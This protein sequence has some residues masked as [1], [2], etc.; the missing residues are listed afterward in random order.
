[1]VFSTARA[2]KKIIWEQSKR[3]ITGTLVALSPIEDKFRQQCKIAVVAARPLTGV[4]ANPPEVDLFF[5]TPEE[6]E[7]DSL[8][9][10]LMVEA[11]TGYFEAYRHTLVGLQRMI[12][13]EYA[14]MPSRTW[15]GLKLTVTARFPMSEH[16]VDLKTTIDK[17]GYTLRIPLSSKDVETPSAAPSENAHLLELLPSSA[18]AALDES[19]RKALERILTKKLA[20]VQGPPGTGKTHVSVTALKFLLSRATEA[21]PP[22]VIAS[23]T[24]HALD[25]MLRHISGFEP[26]FV[27]LGGRSSDQDVIKKRTVYQL[28]RYGQVPNIPGSL[29]GPALSTLRRQEHTMLALLDPIHDQKEPISAELL[30]NLE[31]LTEAQYRS[32]QGRATGWVQALK[33]DHPSGSIAAWLGDELVGVG[34][35]RQQDDLDLEYEDIDPEFEQIKETEAEAVAN[36][37]ENID[38]LSGTWRSISERFQARQR[39]GVTMQAVERA[40]QVDNLWDIPSRMRGAIYT[41]FQQSVKRLIR[42]S[43]R[44]EAQIYMKAVKELQIG[45]WETDSEILRSAKLIGMTT[46]GLS[47][48]RPL[49][50]SVQ[51]RIML[52]EEAAETLE[53]LI[54][55]GCVESLKHL[56]LVG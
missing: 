19:Q 55:A 13:E 25:Q 32:L 37:E 47:K 10:W 15:L 40:L 54:T 53:G 20:I 51:P 17:P 38:S 46:T 21:D 11:R 26:N 27:R 50:A 23:Q 44:A 39:P 56:I 7:I 12:R 52:V 22:I 30:R 41:H 45:K 31:L 24:N 33:S 42:D 2:G 1:M 6:S 28:R 5:A 48:Y 36:D 43:F 49:V 16:L 18:T 9:E 29:R 14:V 35:H 34:G 3:L 4:Q 8:Q